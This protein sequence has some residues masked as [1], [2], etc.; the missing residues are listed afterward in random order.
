MHLPEIRCVLYPAHSIPSAKVDRRA[1]T[2][3]R[4]NHVEEDERIEQ[5][6]EDAPMHG[7]RKVVPTSERSADAHE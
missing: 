3:W 2:R 4:T 5:T 6:V 7:L 1:K